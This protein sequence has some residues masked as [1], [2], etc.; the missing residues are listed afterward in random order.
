MTSTTTTTPG[1]RNRLAGFCRRFLL[2]PRIRWLVGYARFLY[3]VKVKRSLKTMDS[4]NAYTP[5]LM[6]NLKA[7]RQPRFEFT[8]DRVDRLIRPL[9]SIETIGL[10]ARLL[11]IGPR[12]ES[13]ILLLLGY[14]FAPAN[15]RSI[16]LIS[17]SPL[18]SLG[19]MHDI[20]CVSNSFDAILCGW[21]LSYS[22]RPQKVAA[23]II[24]VAHPGTLVAIGV[25]HSTMTP[26]ES[27]RRT[28]YSIVP[29][30]SQDQR[31]NSVKEILDLFGD[32][33]DTVFY[34][35][36]APLK[37]DQDTLRRRQRYGCSVV[38]VIFSVKKSRD[39]SPA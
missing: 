39:G 9:T 5:T 23:E 18:V 22:Q 25:D 14:G 3:F 35:H 13:D 15:I 32:A 24:R 33:V 27:I 37:H 28:G 10:D 11:V 34:S 1:R 17:Y 7:L 16:D 36:D 31:I 21:C 19:D 20:P 4:P 26:E 38:M 6:H 29:P 12:T 8:T 2:I 30:G